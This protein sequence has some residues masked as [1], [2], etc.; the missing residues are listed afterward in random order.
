MNKHYD[1]IVVGGGFA[2]VT[3]AMEAARH[4]QKVLLVEK[5]N[6]LGGAWTTGFMNPFFDFE[7]KSGIVNELV[8]ELKAYNQFVLL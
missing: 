7:N 6:C 4:G 8:S 5:F 3:A 2:G 1:L